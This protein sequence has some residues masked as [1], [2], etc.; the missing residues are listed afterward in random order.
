MYS[1]LNSIT[2][3]SQNKYRQEQEVERLRYKTQELIE[4]KRLEEIA[5][6]KE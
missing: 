5:K 1:L 2:I 4:K 6:R 3:A